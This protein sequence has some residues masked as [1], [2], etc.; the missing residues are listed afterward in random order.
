MQR[1][2]KKDGFAL[3]HPGI[4]IAPVQV[5]RCSVTKMLSENAAAKY[6]HT[7]ECT[8]Q[9]RIASILGVR[10]SSRLGV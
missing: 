3:Q 8:F 1:Q 7:G 4:R 6:H 9:A 10:I 5:L 2:A